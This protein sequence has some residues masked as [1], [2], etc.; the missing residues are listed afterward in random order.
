MKTQTKTFTFDVK[1]SYVN[2]QNFKNGVYHYEQITAPISNDNTDALGCFTIV[3]FDIFMMME[4]KNN[5]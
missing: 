2:K 5:D 4:D 1:R 3:L